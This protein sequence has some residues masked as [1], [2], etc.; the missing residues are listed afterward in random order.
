VTRTALLVLGM[1]RGGT[2][3]VGGTLIRLG[4]QGPRHELPIAADNPSGFHES[5]V[6][7]FF[8]DRLLRAA[9]REW[10]SWTPMEQGRF[11]AVP[12]E[13]FDEEFGNVLDGEYGQAAL[14]MV[15]D[16]RMCRLAPF[17][18]RNLARRDVN[19]LPVLV[20]RSP[21]EVAQ[22][23]IARNQMRLETCLLLWLRHVLDAEFHTR[24]TRRAVVWYSA[25]LDDWRGTVSRLIADLQLDV[26]RD[27]A[28]DGA[29]DAFLRKELRHHRLDSGKAVEVPEPLAGWL[30]RVESSMRR[31]GEQTGDG[32]AQAEL[33]EVRAEFDR[34]CPTMGPIEEE[35]RRAS[36]WA[37]RQKIPGAVRQD[38]SRHSDQAAVNVAFQDFRG[39]MATMKEPRVLQLGARRAAGPTKLRREWIPHAAQFLGSDRQPGVDVDLVAEP[40]LLSSV[41]GTQTFDAVIAC[42]VLES[43]KNPSQVATEIGKVLKPGGL[44]YVQAR[45]LIPPSSG[46]PDYWRFTA[47][48]LSWLFGPD[49]GFELISIAND[50]VAQVR[51]ERLK[52]LESKPAHLNVCLC[53][54][55]I[56]SDAGAR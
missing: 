24:A 5:A 2:S 56:Q 30:A 41:C 37:W 16:P 28:I 23:L 55:K 6:L 50:G 38:E 9:G 48:S 42:L 10:T 29:I 13:Y 14:F 8:H 32:S 18:L 12:A 3:A 33:D 40:H 39:L 31:L 35:A 34:A 20:L 27:A 26:R 47:D 46:A 22:S 21:P 52:D 54:R 15:K 17:W 1:H 7:T 4:A 51:S 11:G 36:S 45:Q 44:V 25:L 19:A 53:A 49:H 43:A